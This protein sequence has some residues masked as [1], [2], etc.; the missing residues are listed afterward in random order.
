MATLAQATQPATQPAA[1]AAPDETLI[2]TEA[3][4]AS[5]E[6]AVTDATAISTDAPGTAPIDAPIAPASS[7]P[8]ASHA[9]MDA[10]PAVPAPT[11]LHPAEVRRGLRL[12][13]IEGAVATVNISITGAV[14]GSVF[15]TGFAL[16]LGANSFQLGLMGALPFIG[17][18]FQFVGAYLEERVGNRRALTL[19]G[20]LAG[21]LVWLFLL[22]LPFLTFL[23]GAELALFLIG[24]AVS[25]AFNG[26][27][28]NAW[29]SW[30]SDLVPARQ[31]GSYFGLRNTV[32]GVAT[33]ASTFLAGQMLDRFRLGGA[34]ALGYAAI[35]GVAIVAALG[36]SALVARQPEPPLRPKARVS[37]REL[38]V[39]PTHDR[40][41]RSYALA[42]AGWA[43]VTGVA[44]P[45]FNAYGL[46]NL[47]LSFS[48]LALTAIVTSAVSLVFTP[49]TGRLQDK[50]GDRKV[51]LFCLIGTIPLPWGWVLSTPENILPLWLT[52]IF[53]GVF[54]PGV[55]QGMVNVLMDRAPA[56]QRGAAMASYSA[57]TGMG[58]LLAGLLGGLIATLLTNVQ[59]SLGPLELAGIAALF[60]LTSLGRAV[61][62]GVFWRTV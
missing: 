9:A 8:A 24:L 49:L 37:V 35:F 40:R 30:M 50:L 60:I 23:R 18:A 47:Q 3:P 58:T 15:L 38:L 44:A 25:Y 2:P 43:L 51:L 48:I 6:A 4:T 17:Q 1:P 13:I 12:S 26:I 62:I 61:M 46:N 22:A 7:A 53:S 21:R 31:R 5:A 11:P 39:G 29:L 56:A 57:I 52:A 41:F 59:F 14:G 28:G 34:E 16:L 45:F 32:V 33:M 54:W 19:Y 36:S 55:N 42:A 27:A 10:T 20:S